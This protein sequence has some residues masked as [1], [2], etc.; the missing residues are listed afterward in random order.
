M[1]KLTIKRTRRFFLSVMALS[2]L[3]GSYL[4]GVVLFYY[5]DSPVFFLEKIQIMTFILCV[6]LFCMLAGLLFYLF[7]EIALLPD[8][9]MS[10]LRDQK[11]I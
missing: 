5:Y 3:M 10:L 9:I 6:G 2:I 7:A 8:K 4:L 1:N 11:N